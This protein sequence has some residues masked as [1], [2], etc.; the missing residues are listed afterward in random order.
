[1]V[2]K[3]TD[4]RYPR[5]RPS[6]LLVLF[7][8]FGVAVGLFVIINREEV[9]DIIIPTPTPEP[10]RSA[11]EF[12]LLAD[13]SEDD[14][15][16]MI[17]IEYYE[18]A[19]RLDATK[20]EF[21]IRLINLLVKTGQPER[22]LEVAEQAIV[23]APE[24]DAVWTVVASAYIANGDR[25]YDLGDPPGADLQYAQARQA[26]DKAIDINPENATAYAYAAAG[27]VLPGDPENYTLAQEMADLAVIVDP[28][29][30]T[31]R[32]YMATVLD[33]QG[34][35]DAA[36]DNYLLGL[37]ADPNNVNLLIGLAY[38]FFGTGNISEAI[39]YFER[40]I[41]ADPNSASA[42]DGLAYMYIQLGQD[43]IAEEHALEAVR[44]NPNVARAHGRLGEA[45]FRQFN[46]EKAVESLE[47]AVSLYGKATDLNSRF[48]LMLG[49]AYIRD[50]FDNCPQ[51]V[52]YFEQVIAV[53]SAWR[54]NAAAS[55][56]ECRRA[57][58]EVSP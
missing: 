47:R 33:Y 26:A 21:F 18:N 50:S 27:W 57:A 25:L 13:L 40:A 6:C 41:E 54:E 29:N 44:L 16:Y 39:I 17:A 10:T 38:N 5:Q 20:P 34:Y 36:R 30:P 23:L 8:L 28:E 42:H 32:Y 9:R 15:E 22:A 52:P 14:G 43:P 48:F 1:M 55:I 2:I 49:N 12:A 46:Y 3:R 56:E 53:S 51:A 7:V 37:D 24:N 19:V 58:L 11:T 31:A 35:Y 4:P 45:Y